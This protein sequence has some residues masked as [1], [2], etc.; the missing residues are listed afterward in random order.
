MERFVFSTASFP[1]VPRF[2]T[3]DPFFQS[4]RVAQ[5]AAEAAE[6]AAEEAADEDEDADDPARPHSPVQQDLP[7]MIDLF[8]QFAAILARISTSA[9]TLAPLPEGCSF[10]V[11]I[12]LRDRPEGEPPFGWPQ[13]WMPS[14]PGLQPRQ[15]KDDD[16]GTATHSGENES[17]SSGPARSADMEGRGDKGKYLGG[18][19]TTPIRAA[20]LGPF[21]MEVWVEE[22]KEKLTNRKEDNDHDH[23]PAAHATKS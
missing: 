17:E 12:E 9:Q 13:P 14:E 21:A 3:D 19:R 18:A 6:E 22:G 23:H 16:D 2:G 5:E 11:A 7:P 1:L 20:E 15:A 8:A 10:T 4:R